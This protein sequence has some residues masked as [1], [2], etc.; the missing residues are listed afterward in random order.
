MRRAVD[1]QLDRLT[2]LDF[3]VALGLVEVEALEKAFE[4]ITARGCRVD[5]DLSVV[6][7]HVGS[8][9]ALWYETENGTTENATLIV[10]AYNHLRVNFS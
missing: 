7:V 8:L 3:E 2:Q 9:Y 6:F 5:V 4:V 1:E 10:L